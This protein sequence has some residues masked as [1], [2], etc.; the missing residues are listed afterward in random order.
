[1]TPP[2]LTDGDG[3]PFRLLGPVPYK[4]DDLDDWLDGCLEWLVNGG[5]LPFHTEGVAHD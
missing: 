2:Q 4:P 5:G 3:W 1:M